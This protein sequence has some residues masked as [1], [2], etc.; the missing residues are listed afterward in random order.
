[1]RVQYQPMR[2]FVWYIPPA[3]SPKAAAAQCCAGITLVSCLPG[4]FCV[5]VTILTQQRSPDLSQP[6]DRL[7]LQPPP[8]LLLWLLGVV[9]R[10]SLLV[11]G[12]W[13]GA[14]CPSLVTGGFGRGVCVVLAPG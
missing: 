1:M 4:I 7:W 14:V 13:S 10:A 6:V 5:S 12:P 8:Q 9:A 11:P 3:L 2:P